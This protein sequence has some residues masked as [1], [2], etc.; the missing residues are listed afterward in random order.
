MKCKLYQIGGISIN[1][2]GT[3]RYVNDFDF[4]GVK[5]FYQVE[6]YEKGFI[7]EWHGHKKEAKYVYVPRGSA[8]IGAVDMET[9]DS[10]KYVLSDKSPKVLY[11]P[12][13]MYNGSQTLEEGTIMIFF[14][15]AT[16]TESKEDDIRVPYNK[17]PIFNKD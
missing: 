1:P 5:R 14:S 12:P 8:W 11:I 7:R 3:L 17:F 10:E 15:T 16:V 9:S 6:N 4:E 13:G 2:T